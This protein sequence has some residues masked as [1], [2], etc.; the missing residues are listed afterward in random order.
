MIGTTRTRVN[1]SM[2]KFR[3]LVSSN[4]T[5]KLKSRSPF[6]VLSCTNNDLAQRTPCLFRIGAPTR[7][8]RE[9]Y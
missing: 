1:L 2:N 6:L 3:K 7:I 9:N 5:A 8:A 4:T